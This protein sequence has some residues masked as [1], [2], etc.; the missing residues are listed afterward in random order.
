M[1]DSFHRLLASVCLEQLER[2]PT[3]VLALSSLAENMRE[4]ERELGLELSLLEE[5]DYLFLSY[6]SLTLLSCVQV[7]IEERRGSIAGRNPRGAAP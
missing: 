1:Y 7:Y 3:R 2:W 5:E 4:G 6:K